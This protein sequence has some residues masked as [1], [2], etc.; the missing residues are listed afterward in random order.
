MIKTC[1][2][3]IA[4]LKKDNTSLDIYLWLIKNQKSEIYPFVFKHF[5]V[6]NRVSS[7][8]QKGIDELILK[9]SKVSSFGEFILRMNKDKYLFSFTSKFMQMADASLTIYD[10]HVANEIKWK[11]QNIKS[12]LKKC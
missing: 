11:F 8:K 9:K 10:S 1:K 7:I 2:N 12:A 3:G 6:L 4:K 5:F